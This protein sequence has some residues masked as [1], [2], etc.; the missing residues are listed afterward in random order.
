MPKIRFRVASLY[1]TV[2]HDDTQ[3]LRPL[4][5]D[6]GIEKVSIGLANYQSV[7][8]STFDL[9]IIRNCRGYH[10][11]ARRFQ[12][13]LNVLDKKLS[14][15]HEDKDVMQNSLAVVQGSIDKATFLSL[16]QKKGVDVVPTQFIAQTDSRTL[17]EIMQ[18]NGWDDIV[19]KPSIGSKSAFAYHVTRSHK[20]L[21]TVRDPAALI[22]SESA[23]EIFAK[24]LGQHEC[25]LV[26]Q[27]IPTLPDKGEI[28]FVFL[29]GSYS[30]AICKKINTLPY[31]WS[32]HEAFGGANEQVSV[33]PEHIAWAQDVYDKVSS[34]Y[35]YLMYGRIDALWSTNSKPMLLE[36]ELFVPRLFLNDAEGA[37]ERYANVIKNKVEALHFSVASQK[38]S[39]P[40]D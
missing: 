25:V 28:S 17:A 12:E 8:W 13:L 37:A 14:A 19:I 31:A 35:G 23:D 1:L 39:G 6:R 7:D 16:M 3:V 4:L 34:E 32:A 40:L 24:L 27:F 38:A 15:V 29:G 18:A 5:L 21:L 11:N 9:V 20:N 2:E 33:D 36:C 30:H 10:L 26:Q 22:P